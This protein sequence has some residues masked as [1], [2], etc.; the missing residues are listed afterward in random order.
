MEGEWPMTT[1]RK[2]FIVCVD[3][4]GCAMDTMNVKH[5]E[6]FGPIAADVFN[7]QDRDAFLKEWNRVNLFS[8]TRGINRFKALELVL[9]WA[10]DNG[11]DQIG[12]ISKLT[13]WAKNADTVSNAA[14]EELIAKDSSED[15]VKA[16]DWSVKVN[17]GIEEELAGNDK[18]FDGAKDGLEAIS[19]V[20][21]IA[22]VSS[23]NLGALE[24]EWNRHGLMQYVDQ[25]YG[26]ERGSKQTAIAELISQGYDQDKVLMVG[27]APG[28]KTAAEKNDVGFYPILFNK[29]KESWD[30][31][32]NE[33]IPTFLEG[34]YHPEYNQKMA[35]EFD[36]HLNSAVE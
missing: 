29:E 25:V 16:L 28:D 35:D 13:D 12:D 32:V 10:K 2:D 15:L 7:V 6:F 18:P 27:D 33:A 30:R 14:L 8:A 26:Q 9:N 5:I 19:K 11:D 34:N 3:S 17:D 23:A 24:S 4:D 20:A 31:L 21:N 22:I 36:T 1:E